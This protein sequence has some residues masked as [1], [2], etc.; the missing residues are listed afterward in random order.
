MKET[1]ILLGLPNLTHTQILHTRSSGASV[2][3]EERN[4]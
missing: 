3:D 1:N 4:Q 2:G